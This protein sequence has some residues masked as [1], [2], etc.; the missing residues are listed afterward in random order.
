MNQYSKEQ[1][2]WAE[3][4]IQY[5]VC[6][7]YLVDELLQ[8]HFSDFSYDNAENVYQD[9]CQDCGST[10]SV[11]NVCAKCGSDRYD[12]EPLEIFEWWIIPDSWL[13]E[14]LQKLGQPTLQA[15]GLNFW[16][17]MTT[18]Q[19]IVLDGVFQRIKIE[20]EKELENDGE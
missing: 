16:G 12:V 9:V 5:L 4:Q 18:G 8:N 7:S 3:N 17:R 6:A 20:L 1:N 2:D 13:F 10:E 19:A 11:H 14:R 15:G